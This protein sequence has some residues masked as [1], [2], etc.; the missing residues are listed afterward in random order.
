M[1]F[2]CYISL[3]FLFCGWHL[4]FFF[5]CLVRHMQLVKVKHYT[6]DLHVIIV[7]LF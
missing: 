4:C 2:L 3:H 6:D 5:K 7:N 1:M